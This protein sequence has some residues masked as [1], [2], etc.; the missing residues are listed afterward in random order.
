MGTA[1]VVRGVSEI[2]SVHLCWGTYGFWLPNDPRGSGSKEVWAPELRP[3]GPATFVEDRA[4]SRGRV[5][6]DRRLRLEAKKHLQ[7]PA[8]LFIGLQARAVARGFAELLKEID[9]RCHACTVLPDHVHL[10]VGPS[11]IP[12]HVLT[13]RLKQHATRQLKDEGIHPF[14]HLLDE[15]GEVPKC[16]QRGGWKVYL[17]DEARV[18]QTIRYVEDNPLKEGKPKQN[19]N[20]VTPFGS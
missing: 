15:D 12:A 10:V 18:R 5:L 7:R 11:E 2:L 4:K 17:F 16:W 1:E 9:I 19:W 3:F 20:F 6:H 13:I 8:V 14:Q